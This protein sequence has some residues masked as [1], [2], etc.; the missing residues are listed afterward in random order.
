VAITFP[1]PT[2]AIV[3]NLNG[4]SRTTSTEDCSEVTGNQCQKN[5]SHAAHKAIVTLLTVTGLWELR[6][7][8]THRSFLTVAY[9]KLSVSW[10][11]SSLAALFNHSVMQ[12]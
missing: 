6:R 4:Y 3:E 8:M 12:T 2:A 5:I 1:I 7:T 9:N 10:R 11:A